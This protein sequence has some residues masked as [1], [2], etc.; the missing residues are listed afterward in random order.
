ME[1]AGGFN[2]FQFGLVGASDT[3]TGATP[4]LRGSVPLDQPDADGN[5]YNKVYY[6]LWG[7][8]GITGVWAEENTRA[9]I[10]AALRRKEAFATS[11]PRIVVRLFA[12][13]NLADAS[14]EEPQAAERGYA[15]GVPMGG[16]LLPGDGSPRFTASAR[17]DPDSAPLQRLQI[18]KG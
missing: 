3:H 2:P 10:Y 14:E 8:S 15:N 17:R 18:I 7:A 6:D 4:A 13:F 12:R 9:S 11:G 16:D 1:A 5:S